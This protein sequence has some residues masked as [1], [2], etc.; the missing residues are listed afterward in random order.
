[1]EPEHLI[2]YNMSIFVLQW[3]GGR[4]CSGEPAQHY[5]S[6]A[7]S[8]LLDRAAASS[9]VWIHSPIGPACLGS[10]LPLADLGGGGHQ[11]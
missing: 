4:D 11:G 3:R 9:L 7:A 10:C 8:S 2:K 1:M 6:E 5:S